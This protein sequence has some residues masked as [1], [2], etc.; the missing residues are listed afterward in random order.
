MEFR[1]YKRLTKK[2][3]ILLHTQTYSMS[4][5]NNF[6]HDYRNCTNLNQKLKLFN[7]TSMSSNRNLLKQF[8]LQNVV[9]IVR[10]MDNKRYEQG[11]LSINDPWWDNHAEKELDTLMFSH[12]NG[13]VGCIYHNVWEEKRIIDMME[14]TT[15]LVRPV[16]CIVFQYVIE[17]M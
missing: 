8:D 1:H 13:Y 6:I 2:E 7:A 16:C 14:D 15:L 11:M 4:S 10:H 9:A 12:L 3:L 5:I 17:Y